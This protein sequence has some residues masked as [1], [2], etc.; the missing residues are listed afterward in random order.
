MSKPLWTAAEICAIGARFEP[1]SAEADFEATG[2]SIDSRT[3]SRGDLF[4]AIHGEARDGHEFVAKAL[5]EGAAGALVDH[6]PTERGEGV[7]IYVDDTLKG[8]ERLGLAARER[9]PAKRIA[10]T[11]S[12]GKTGTKEALRIALAASGRTHASDASYNNLWGVPLTLARMP[13]ET[14]FGVFEIG[15]NHPGEITPL[16]KQVRPHAAIITTVEPVHLQFFDSVEE[17]AEAKAEIFNGLEPG[18]TAVLNIDN[19]HYERLKLRAEQ[20]G[21]GRIIAFGEDARADAF[22]EAI[23][24]GPEGSNV[25]ARICGLS[26]EY[27]LASPGRHVAHN[28]LAVL[29]GVYAIGADLKAAAHA[30]NMVKPPSGRGAR[31]IVNLV[32]GPLT[33]IDESYNANPVSMRA[34]IAN[35][36]LQGAAAGL[37]RVAVLGDMLELGAAAPSLHA[38]LAEPLGEARIDKVYLCGPMMR[39]LFDALP[40]EQRGAYAQSSKEL[41]EIVAEEVRAGDVVMI[42]GSLGSRMKAVVE[43][44]EAL[45]RTPR[46]ANGN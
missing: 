8:L 43:R 6:P 42:K 38:A 1:Q 31:R 5:S 30:L 3:L 23:D 29:A 40:E 20:A 41:A 35:L 21:A 11:G 46:T 13:R 2:V 4:V 33:L 16:S 24:L 10:V 19:P 37:R 39:S 32:G 18:G 26:V 22:L 25:R 44:L 34:A 15:M 28:S 45:D 27:H 14:E 17:I 36:A 12:V 7:L 9:S